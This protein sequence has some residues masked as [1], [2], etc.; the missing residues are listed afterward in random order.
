[1][2][3]KVN[4]VKL[5]PD[6]GVGDIWTHP[7][8]CQDLDMWVEAE[9]QHLPLVP[10]NLYNCPN[11]LVIHICTFVRSTY[12]CNTYILRMN[13]YLMVDKISPVS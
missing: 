4:E 12:V 7:T 9:C 13:E 1:M 6:Q 10:V 8:C 2:R 5:I 11:K 3:L